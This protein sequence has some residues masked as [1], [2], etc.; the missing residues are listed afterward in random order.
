MTTYQI[1]MLSLG[2]ATLC[3]W[4]GYQLVGL[5]SSRRSTTTVAPT[6]TASECVAVWEDL[7]GKCEAS[8]RLEAV[9]ELQ[10]VFPHL[11]GPCKATTAAK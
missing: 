7:V 1:V 10:K 9:T 4:G 3:G 2:L 5:I 8:G 6:A 11:A